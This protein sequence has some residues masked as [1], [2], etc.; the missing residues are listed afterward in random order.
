MFNFPALFAPD[1]GADSSSPS[2]T[3]P[4]RSPRAIPGGSP[5]AAADALLTAM[6]FYF[7]DGR[8]VH[9]SAAQD[10]EE[11]VGLPLSV[12]AKVALLNEMCARRVRPADL[13]RAM[14]VR[15]QEVTRI[16][17]LSHATKIETVGKASLGKTLELSVH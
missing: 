11:L 8:P 6:D 14:D 17:D 15:P 5:L 12:Q 13:A 4:R 16:L 1:P 9:P 2:A 7:E 10:G 3:S